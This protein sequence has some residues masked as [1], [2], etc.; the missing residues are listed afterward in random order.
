M[1]WTGGKHFF[2]N[3]IIE[4]WQHMAWA[5][6]SSRFKFVENRA[7]RA[8]QK[9]MIMTCVTS[10]E[11]IKR[12]IKKLLLPIALPPHCTKYKRKKL[13]NGNPPPLHGPQ[14]LLRSTTHDNHYLNRTSCSNYV[15][16]CKLSQRSWLQQP[17]ERSYSPPC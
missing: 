2:Q 13:E 10:V 9:C 3:L 14:H 16:G 7:R 12:F 8:K 4:R 6:R 17:T 1:S 11:N 15:D 5:R